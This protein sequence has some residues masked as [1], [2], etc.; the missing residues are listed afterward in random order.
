[1]NC[2]KIRIGKLRYVFR[3][4]SES[5]AHVVIDAFQVVEKSRRGDTPFE[6]RKHG[7]FGTAPFV[8]RNNPPS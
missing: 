5:G 4:A 6:I 8:C 1:M 7:P 2:K 3:P